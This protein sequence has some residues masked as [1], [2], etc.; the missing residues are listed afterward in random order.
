MDLFILAGFL[1]AWFG[2]AAYGLW[3]VVRAVRTGEIPA[4]AGGTAYRR[5]DHPIQFRV[6]AVFLGG[7]CL[8]HLCV[9]LVLVAH[10]IGA[11]LHPTLT[12][13]Q[14]PATRRA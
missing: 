5:A 3:A 14:T 6:W 10:I 9:W 11:G 2:V 8:I 12:H 1:S 4:R 7:A 13:V